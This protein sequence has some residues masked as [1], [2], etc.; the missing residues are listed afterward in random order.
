MARA[1]DFRKILGRLKAYPIAIAAGLLTLVFAGVL[2][3]RS[4]SL[5]ALEFSLQEKESEWNRVSGNLTRAR[6]LE[7]H[8]AQIK[9]YDAEVNARLMDPEERAL[10]Y[11]Y[12]YALEAES[13]VSLASLNQGGVVETKNS[14]EPGI[15][16]FKKYRLIG[17]NLAVEGDFTS[18]VKFVSLLAD[19]EY[20]ARISSFSI[21]R[22]PQAAAGTLTVNLQMQVL[23]TPNES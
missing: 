4:S 15:A 1:P 8:L 17:Y 6:D 20:F 7:A 10:N 19:G 9:A 21:A 5:D 14:N 22:A 12:F 18:I 2:F 13:G 3:L 11:D 23:G 16:E